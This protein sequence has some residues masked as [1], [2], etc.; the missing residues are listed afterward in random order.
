VKPHFLPTILLPAILLLATCA[1]AQQLT[2]ETASVKRA[3]CKIENSLDPAMISLKGDPLK[4]LLKE[5]FHVEINLIEGPAWL[6]TEC[7][8]I[9]AKMPEGSKLDQ[10]G[11]MLQAL[12]VERFKMSFHKETRQRTGY[13]LLVDKGGPKFKEDD[14][15]STFMGGR[16]TLMLRRNGGGIKSV[17]T[18]PG[19]AT[20]LSRAGYGPVTDETKLTARYDIDLSWSPDPAFEHPPAL[21]EPR[22]DTPAP[23]PGTGLFEAVREKLGLRLEKRSIAVE[24]VVIDHMERVPTGN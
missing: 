1:S 18:M 19:L 16:A 23:E 12:F 13:A 4:P 14:G 22:P 11:A 24:Y 15:S 9:M 8:D 17:M 2:F 7:Y 21:A 6:E 3:E 5:A 20:F 10:L